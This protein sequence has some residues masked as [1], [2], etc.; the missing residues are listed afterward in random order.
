MCR[1]MPYIVYLLLVSESLVR[2]WVDNVYVIQT[3]S[4][5]NKKGLN[6]SRMIKIPGLDSKITG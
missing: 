1:Y 6:L 2:Q 5:N 3:K 4:S